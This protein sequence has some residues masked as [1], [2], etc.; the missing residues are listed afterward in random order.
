M[1]S[2]STN[3]LCAWE[4]LIGFHVWITILDNPPETNSEAL[5]HAPSDICFTLAI[6]KYVY[7]SSWS[8]SKSSK[9]LW[10]SVSVFVLNISI[11]WLLIMSARVSMSSEFI[12][13]S[14]F[15]YIEGIF[16]HPPF[17]FDEA[18]WANDL[19]AVV[20]FFHVS[21]WISILCSIILVFADLGWVYSDGC[22]WG[23][24]N[25]VTF[26]CNVTIRYF[27]SFRA[28]VFRL[29]PPMIAFS[30]VCLTSPYSGNNFS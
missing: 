1:A 16:F 22:G 13:K 24:G 10:A 17:V 18:S 27:L 14:I 9:R 20:L 21:S 4:L 12:A 29:E 30:S 6:C 3:A 11:P 19:L 8:F 7:H 28:M 25:R 26:F 5:N 23:Y 2:D 15:V